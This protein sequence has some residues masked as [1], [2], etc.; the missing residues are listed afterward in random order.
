[1]KKALAFV[2]FLLMMSCS[3]DD[4]VVSDSP[5]ANGDYA[6][7]TLD[8]D[9]IA[10]LSGLPGHIAKARLSPDG[11]IIVDIGT[12]TSSY[13]DRSM[14]LSIW[15]DPS[16]NVYQVIQNFFGSVYG[17][18][19]YFRNYRN[20]PSHFFNV[21]DFSID[22]QSRRVKFSFSGRLYNDPE[23]VDSEFHEVDGEV[24]LPYSP[25]EYEQPF[26][27][28]YHIADNLIPQYC[29]ADFN[30]QRWQAWFQHNPSVFT[31]YDPLRIEIHFDQN[32]EPGTFAVTADDDMND[33][34]IS[35]FNPQTM[36]YD[37]YDVTGNLSYSYKEYHGYL[38]YSY[39]GTFDLTAVNPDNPEDVIQITDG[40]F[41]CMQ[42]L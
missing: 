1:M 42:R 28:Y 40:T 14:N 22:Q 18:F 23:S 39:I 32:A 33:I 34:K 36:T 2:C 8:G 31:T 7:V 29:N 6:N 24:S 16:G 5:A 26:T 15:I 13:A 25:P 30:G 21:G 19:D 10:F 12:G 4:A 37:Y 38:Y 17:G 41:R 20:F 27:L 11:F 3:G 35:R 9:H